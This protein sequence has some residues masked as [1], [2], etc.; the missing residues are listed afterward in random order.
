MMAVRCSLCAEFEEIAHRALTT[1]ANT[2]EL[3]ELKAFVEKAESE[4]MFE[5]ERRLVD[6][7]ITLAFLVDY[8]AFSPAEM[9]SNTNTFIWFDRMADI[10]DEHRTIIA[11]KRTQ[12]EE[13]LKVRLFPFL[14]F[15]LLF[16]I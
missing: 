15:C 3:M 16:I 13:A 5:L 9:K 7:R 8:T 11:E 1:P 14:L 6:A 12:Y 4:T 2:K 10:F